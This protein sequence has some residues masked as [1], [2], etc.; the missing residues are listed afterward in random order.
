MSPKRAP[1]KLRWGFDIKSAINV[2]D[3]YIEANR[4]YLNTRQA[5]K[6]IGKTA[7]R[8]RPALK[9]GPMNRKNF[10]AENNF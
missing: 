1:R 6:P 5:K 7:P 9:K 3:K 8:N 2:L 10:G 4:N